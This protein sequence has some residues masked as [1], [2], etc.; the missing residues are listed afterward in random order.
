MPLLSRLDSAWAQ[1]W[2]SLPEP[3]QYALRSEHYT[4][5]PVDAE[6]FATTYD[7]HLEGIHTPI[8]EVI[9]RARTYAQTPGK[10][11]PGTISQHHSGYNTGAGSRTQQSKGDIL[12]TLHKLRLRADSSKPHRDTPLATNLWLHTTAEAAPLTPAPKHLKPSP[13][14]TTKYINWKLQCIKNTDCQ[15]QRNADTSHLSR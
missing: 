13:K 2:A 7:R 6:Y 15:T 9:E 4:A 5:D 8:Q 14:A 3:H 11:T 1:T 10:P 12:H